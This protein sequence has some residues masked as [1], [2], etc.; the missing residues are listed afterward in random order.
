MTIKRY[1]LS[2]IPSAPTS[3]PITRQSSTSS[4]SSISLMRAAMKFAILLYGTKENMALKKIV[5]LMLTSM[6]SKIQYLVV[7]V[8]V[9]AVFV[10]VASPGPGP[11]APL[12]QI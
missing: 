8:D 7:V 5:S 9:V 1:C 6:F 12:L 3:L 10:L 4:T 11:G 2:V